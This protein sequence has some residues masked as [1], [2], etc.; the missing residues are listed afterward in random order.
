MAGS[1]VMVGTATTGSSSSEYEIWWNT[2]T[3]EVRAGGVYS[4]GEHTPNTGN[5]AGNAPNKPEA[6]RKGKIFIGSY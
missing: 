2:S 5:S 3:G 4:N 6:L 1:W